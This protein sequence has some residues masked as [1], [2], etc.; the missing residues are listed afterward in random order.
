[1]E[2]NRCR[3]TSESS[4]ESASILEHPNSSSRR[5]LKDNS[6][7]KH[8]LGQPRRFSAF[9]PFCFSI[10]LC[11]IL[12]QLALSVSLWWSS[13]VSFT[14]YINI[15]V[16]YPSFP[17]LTFLLSLLCF[18]CPVSVSCCMV[19]FS[20]FFFFSP[21][22]ISIAPMSVL[23]FPSMSLSH[24]RCQFSFPASILT[25][26]SSFPCLISLDLPKISST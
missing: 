6:K 21:F 11:A 20:M 22:R 7:R 25:V 8:Y 4:V 12:S 15:Y 24:V 16:Q 10:S 17:P 14:D 5:G 13:V 18:L 23:S 1:M 9:H 2:E 3:N 19:P 26:P